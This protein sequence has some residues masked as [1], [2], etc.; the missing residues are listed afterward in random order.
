MRGVVNGQQIVEFARSIQEFSEVDQNKYLASLTVSR[1][2]FYLSKQDAIT[3]GLENRAVESF[4][5]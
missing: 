4:A 2:Y 3:D 5:G 1:M